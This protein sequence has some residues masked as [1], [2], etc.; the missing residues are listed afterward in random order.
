[1][2]WKNF[3]GFCFGLSYLASSVLKHISRQ[4]EVFLLRNFRKL[5]TLRVVR[6]RMPSNPRRTLKERLLLS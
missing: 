3:K 2:V 4:R 6:T 1:M 5:V